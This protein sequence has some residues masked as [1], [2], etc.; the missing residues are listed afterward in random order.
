MSELTGGQALAKSL[1]SEGVDTIF[2]LPGDQ[3]MHALD[4]LYD[5][6]ENIRYITTR[7]EQATTYMAD[8]FARSSG[9]PGVAMVVPG[10]G[11]YNAAAGLATAYAACSPVLMIAGQVNRDDIGRGRG[12]L[13]DVHDQLEIIRPVTK[14]AKR[15]LEAEGV[16]IAVQQAFAQL[17]T[18]PARPVEIE[19][20][21]EAFA[22]IAEVSLCEPLQPEACAGDPE[23]LRQA[24]KWLAEAERPLLYAGGGV[25]L[26]DASEAFTALVEKLEA[27]AV[28]S[29]DGKGAISA[30]HSHAVGTAWVNRRLHPVIQDADVILAVGT[31]FHNSGAN[32]QQ[33]VIHIDANPDE[34]GTN[35]AGAYGIE[36]DARL[37]LE[38]LLAEL[39]GGPPRTSRTSEFREA[40]IR[41]EAELRKVGPQ[42]ALV[43]TLRA[44]LPDETIVVAGTTTVG[45]MSHM[46]FP[47]YEPRSY[48]SS[49][50]M[51][52]LGFAFP[53][54]LGAKV[55]RP[56]RPVVSLIGD[57][58][59]LFA[60]SELATA[61]QYDIAAV[62][63]VFNDNAYGNS[64]RD[65][66]ERF[67]GRE[68]GTELRN[69]DFA[70]LARS[71]GAD[72]ICISGVE[73]LAGALGE[74]LAGGRPALIECPID[75]LPS[76]F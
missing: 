59:F 75:R 20:P 66:R 23:R 56:E 32:P 8:G 58:G 71:F 40:R 52:T 38:A 41:V 68:I 36:G 49:S 60:A 5:E 73:Q 34:P 65:Q 70:A 37:A 44:A 55:A 11:V 48:L 30:R 6:R 9:R 74:A 13:H 1:I 7:H 35:F 10:V 61:I 25:V 22:E 21:P 28:T 63:V 47:V 46:L 12:L 19:I 76:P 72:G 33:R 14:W 50:Y 2:G 18:A 3:L 42:A 51:G 17:R 26:G 27:A 4:A 67:A 24:A 54:A 69:P 16:P 45:Y 29:R 64:N 43:D 15:V 31:R 57:G 62:T 39:D 53:T